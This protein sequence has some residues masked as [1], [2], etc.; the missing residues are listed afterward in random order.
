MT[1]KEKAA[2][3]GG[4]NEWETRDIPRLG[5]PSM[6]CSD[7]PSGLRRQAGTG[8]HLGLNP[9]LPATCFP[10]PSLMACSWDQKLEEE[11]GAA[12]GE[13]A[14]EQGVDILLGPG[15]NIKRNPLCG[16]NFEYFSEDPCLSGKMAAAFIRGVEGKGIAACPKHFAVNSQELRRMAMNAVVDERTLREIY[17]TGFE[18]AVKEGKCRALMTSYNEVNGIYANEHPHLL[19]DILRDEWGFLGAVITDWGGSNDHCAGVKNGSSLEMP[20]AGLNS[21]AALL[22]GAEE[23]RITQKDLDDRV[24][25]LL[26]LLPGEKKKEKQNPKDSGTFEKHHLLAR[27]ACGES[28]VLL[29]NQ[30]AVLPLKPGTRAAV[31]GDFAFEPRYQG[32]GSSM[33]NAWKVDSVKEC[34]EGEM[35]TRWKKMGITVSGFSRGYRRDGKPD[36]QLEEEAL[37]LAES[38]DQILFFFGLNEQ[39]E[40][41]GL[42]RSHLKIPENQI[43]LLEKLSRLEIPITGILCAGG[44]VEAPWEIHLKALLY[45]GLWGQAGAGAVLDLLSGELNPGGKLAETWPL[46]YEDTP[47]FH[48]Y[49]SQ[50]RNSQYREGIYVGYRYYDTA[51]IPVRFSFGFGLSYTEF[52]Y[53]GLKISPQG[54]RF[55]LENSGSRDGAEIVQLYT[56]LPEAQVFRPKRELKG[57]CKV[58]L[59]AREKKTVFLPFDQNTFRYWNCKTEKWEREKG[60]YRIYIGSGLRDI[61]LEGVIFQEK[62]TDCLPW[63]GEELPSYASGRIQEVPDEEYERLLGHPVPDGGWKGELGINDALCQMYYAKSALARWICHILKH[64][65]EKTRE[66]GIPD[67]NAVFQY[68]MPF[69]AMAKMTGGWISMDMAESLV[70][71]AN[72]HF[73]HGMWG[74]I[75]GFFKNRTLER[76]YEA[77]LQNKVP[78][79]KS[80]GERQR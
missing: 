30:E 73:F 60:V 54:V 58:Y 64:R 37:H 7:G 11:L 78:E 17:L 59:K 6:V 9:S 56:G 70:C 74:F 19:K 12:L 75:K 21:A 71:M 52:R 26:S 72:G 48:Y 36:A 46:K 29:K 10:S 44:A 50:E 20:A 61:R 34:L 62:T 45:T 3:L 38:A 65:L 43:C 35:G 1:L 49:P 68:N 22:R 28:A 31:I 32:A 27:R 8:D 24:R 79:K 40:T 76:R 14:S 23:G 13:E 25:E 67:L 2:F 51:D 53:S 15:L 33:V 42:D 5:I 80:R 47:S 66:R 63:K 69:R 77:E 4:K 16:R 41:E 39:Y 55:E 18:T 57:F